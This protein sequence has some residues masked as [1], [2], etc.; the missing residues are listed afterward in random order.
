M[1]VTPTIQNNFPTVGASADTWGGTLN[2]RGGETY[3]DIKALANQGNATETAAATAQTTA[4]NAL[5]RAGGT[6]TGDAVLANVAPTNVYSAGFRGV[7]VESND[8]NITFALAQAGKMIR[9]NGTTSRTWTIPNDSAVNFPIGSVIALRAFSS[10]S[11]TVARASGVSLRVA[12]QTTDKNC[13][14]VS[15]GYATLTKED[16]NIWVISGAGVS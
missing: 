9:L 10:G 7:P 6:M 13:T 16:P 15:F 5:A 4:N 11:I 3:V 1:P 12:G 2:A 14:V 8:S